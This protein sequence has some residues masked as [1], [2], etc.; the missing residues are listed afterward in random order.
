MSSSVGKK[1]V[2][3]YL[4][5]LPPDLVRE[6]KAIAARRGVTLAS[7]VAESLAHAISADADSALRS[8]R[9]AD[10][11]LAPRMQN[12]QNVQNVQ[13]ANNTVNADSQV[14]DTST[15]N[16]VERELNW[17]ENNREQLARQYGDEFVAIIDNRVVDH[18]AEF[19]ALA[20]RV[21]TAH[22]NGERSIFM[23]RV[24]TSGRMLRL[25]SPRIARPA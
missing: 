3:V 22:G 9:S 16:D 13:N 25:R 15:A 12:A 7:F 23:P 10:S 11:T 4:R 2:P 1:P 17:Y 18:D 14:D 20:E 19:E 21:F 24:R 5:G 8:V 6:A